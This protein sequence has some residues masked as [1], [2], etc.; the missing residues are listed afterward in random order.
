[1]T[2]ITTGIRP[3]FSLPRRKEEDNPEVTIAAEFEKRLIA[4]AENGLSQ[5]SIILDIRRVAGIQNCRFFQIDKRPSC[6]VGE[7]RNYSENW[8]TTTMW[9]AQF[10]DGS[11]L[12]FTVIEAFEVFWENGQA[13][14]PGGAFRDEGEVGVTMFAYQCKTGVEMPDYPVP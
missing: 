14:N 7:R 11:T 9:W 4:A 13:I 1:M 3:V 10:Q 6:E 2:E 8:A 5:R 12:G